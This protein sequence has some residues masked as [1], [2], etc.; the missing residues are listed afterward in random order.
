MKAQ[1]LGRLFAVGAGSMLLVGLI[2]G[3]GCPGAG[4]GGG[5]SSVSQLLQQAT[6]Q[7]TQQTGVQPGPGDQNPVQVLPP[8][9]L[10]SGALLLQTFTTVPFTATFTL[11]NTT[12]TVDV[13]VSSDNSGSRVT[14]AITDPNGAS[15]ATVD[16]PDSSVSTTS[17]TPTA[18]GNYT[19]TA[20]ETATMADL[21]ILR[22]VQLPPNLAP[23]GGGNG[24]GAGDHHGLGQGVLLNQ[25]FTTSPFTGTITPVQTGE[26]VDVAVAGKNSASRLTV[27]VTD[28]NGATVASVTS[29]TTNIST[30]SFTPE[31]AGQYSLTATETGTA[32]NNYLALVVQPQR[33]PL[34]PHLDDGLIL[35]QTFTAA[36]ITA[37]FTPLE[38]GQMLEILVA[39]NNTASRVTF[40]VT[41]PSAATVAQVTTPSTEIS[42]A[43]FTPTASGVYTLTATETG[44]AGTLYAVRVGPYPSQA[45]GLHGIDGGL[46]TQR[47]N[48]APFTANFTPPQ[49]G[50]IVEIAASGRN[51]GSRLTLTVTD[52]ASV[53]VGTLS[54][55][56]TN[57]STLVFTPETAGAYALTG[58]ETGTAANRY[59]V[60]VD[61]PR[62]PTADLEAAEGMLLETT[63]AAAP[64][65][66]KFEA[67]QTDQVVHI[68]VASDNAASRIV[69]TVTDAST[70][71]VAGVSNPSANVSSTVFTPAAA[72]TFT[73]T[74]TETGTAGTHYFVLVTQQGNPPAGV[75]HGQD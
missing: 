2:L 12:D 70:N 66:A 69:F 71:A 30:V 52:P 45:V 48:A 13:L 53:S 16:S 28:P 44:T 22:V 5:L 50:R 32:S 33:Q 54:N 34:P 41:D 49:T 17:F 39:G 18:A 62:E 14:L 72:G 24:G 42:S 37:T 61:Q 6:D 74:V 1:R 10:G 73:L 27:T 57:V 64:I 36:P 31:L 9:H 63:A 7:T 59:V 3:Q 68:F 4:P 46:L 65:T 23:P 21:Y 35:D 56:T 8:L 55:P 15:V 60:N 67:S 29:P 40:V 75:D 58:T 51:P 47:F 20:S 43:T 26:I 38:T 25:T 19:L 11:T